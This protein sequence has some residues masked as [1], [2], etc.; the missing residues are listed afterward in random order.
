MKLKKSVLIICI[1]ASGILLGSIFILP[2]F[3]RSFKTGVITASGSAAK[4]VRDYDRI[5]YEIMQNESL[6]FLKIGAAASS[7]T[8]K[9]GEPQ[10][11]GV[12]EEWGA[13]GMYHQSWNY[14]SAGI[15]LDMVRLD[16]VQKINMIDISAPCS[17]KTKNNIGI[18]S[19]KQDVLVAYKNEIDEKT[20]T[21]DSLVA[22]SIYGGM[23]FSVDK[24]RVT[25]IFIG[26][27]AE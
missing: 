21:A 24:D 17:Y 10:Q 12:E 16:D 1:A 11:R 25:G 8:A 27:A 7:V 9:L 15:T 3:L 19:P 4:A 13:D 6:D 22:G 23:I 5:G 14:I 2:P 20:S 18:G 26:A